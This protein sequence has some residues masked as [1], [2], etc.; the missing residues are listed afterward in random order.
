MSFGSTKK[1]YLIINQNYLEP[2]TDHRSR[3][4]DTDRGAKRL[5]PFF[6]LCYV[7]LCYSGVRLSYKHVQKRRTD[8]R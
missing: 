4:R 6:R 2:E 3:F 8:V 1:F 5:S 7:K